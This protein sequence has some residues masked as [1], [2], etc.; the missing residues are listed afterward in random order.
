MLAQKAA[1]KTAHKP[2]VE[3]VQK[4]P[5]RLPPVTI[6]TRAAV[7]PQP[8]LPYFYA[9][10][11]NRMAAFVCGSQESISQRGNPLLLH[12]PSG[13]G[14][15]ALALNIA[16]AEAALREKPKV[17]RLPAIDFARRYA[18]AVDSDDIDHFRKLFDTAHVLL[19]DDVHLIADKIP[20]QDELASRLAVRIDAELVTILTCRRLPTEIRGFRPI[21]ASRMLPGLAIQVAL[22][23]P[24][25]KRCLLQ[26][27]A[28]RSELDIDDDLLELLAAGISADSTAAD[29]SAAISHVRVWCRSAESR[30]TVQAIQSA[31]NSTRSEIQLSMQDIATAVAR[32]FKLKIA[33]LK[34]PTRRQQVVR[35]RALAM[36][37][38]RKLT[39]RSLQQ[40]GTF[41]GG[42]DH[43]TVLHACR[44]TEA[45][46][47]DNPDL[48]QVAD[49]VTEQLRHSA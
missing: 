23:G 45:L 41:F 20:A 4:V 42:R 48:S 39:G 13:S 9:G 12:G 31:I 25:A 22:P 28:E 8:L 36:F 32:R 35:A 49:E 44:K 37:L 17:L 14:K 38:G 11:E 19:I 2:N 46:L 18:E 3:S 26:A 1:Q 34:G 27:L 29:L 30:P 43:T 16:A 24:D 40:I 21:L 7:V 15:S 33:D 5:L 47:V 10:P 6:R